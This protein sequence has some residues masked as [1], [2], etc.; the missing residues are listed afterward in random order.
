M[1]E[2]LSTESINT[3]T[4]TNRGVRKL[5]RIWYERIQRLETGDFKDLC[6]E[7]S[8][9]ITREGGFHWELFYNTLQ[10]TVRPVRHIIRHLQ[11][12]KLICVRG[13]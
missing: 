2:Y 1:P 4:H 10:Y 6:G 3:R 7:N 13:G 12:L 11:A 9:N 5:L 8:F